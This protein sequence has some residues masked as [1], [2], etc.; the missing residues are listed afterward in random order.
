[1]KTAKYIIATSNDCYPAER[2][3]NLKEAD[4]CF[5]ELV[6]R[7]GGELKENAATRYHNYR[8]L[9]V[10]VEIQD[11]IIDGNLIKRVYTNT[12]N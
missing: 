6:R 2:F 9:K 11:A 10:A 7:L 4:K 8:D 12:N 3:S 5:N 1:M